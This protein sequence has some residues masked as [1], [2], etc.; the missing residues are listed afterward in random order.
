[1]LVSTG[2]DFDRLAGTQQIPHLRRTAMTAWA[3]ARQRGGE[4]L[5]G[6][7]RLDTADE[8]DPRLEAG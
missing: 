2:R 3:F 5:A 4:E 7:V 6:P 8:V 1:M